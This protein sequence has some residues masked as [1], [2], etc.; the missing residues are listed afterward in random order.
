MLGRSSKS[1]VRRDL[2]VSS[3]GE[4]ETA[5]QST[6]KV[7]SI[8]D[9]DFSEISQTVEKNRW[10]HRWVREKFL[11]WVDRKP[12]IKNRAVWKDYWKR[13]F[14]TNNSLTEKV[15]STSRIVES[16][17]M[18]QDECQ[19]MVTGVTTR[20]EIPTKSS[21]MPHPSHKYL[22]DIVDKFLESLKN[23][24]QQTLGLL[25]LPKAL[26]KAIP[27]VDRRNEELEHF[28]DL[29][30]TSL[31]VY[32]NISE[33][34][35][36][37]LF[38]SLLRGDDFH[39]YRNMTDTNRASLEDIIATFRRDVFAQPVATARWKWGQLHFDPSRQKFQDRTRNRTIRETR[40]GGLCRRCPK[41][42]RNLFLCENATLSWKSVE[43]CTFGK[44]TIGY[45][46]STPWAWDGT[47]RPLGTH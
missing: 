24:T 20:P 40:P 38:H 39:T 7:Q 18:T 9:K 34:E 45:I 13:K 42:H 47:K 37:Q 17:E 22:N 32:P 3:T 33:E 41:V 2:P 26:S 46:G 35:Q 44:R 4:P 11:S 28:G 5:S 36:L 43:P 31:K 21:S 8:S 12:V 27:T 10:R 6:A 14:G 25:R 1:K 29:F 30:M 19:Y 16:N 23:E 15:A